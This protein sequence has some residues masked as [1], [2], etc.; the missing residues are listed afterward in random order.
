MLQPRSKI[1]RKRFKQIQKYMKEHLEPAEYEREMELA[2]QF[3]KRLLAT[4]DGALWLSF[5]EQKPV[6]SADAEAPI[7]A[8]F[9]MKDG[10]QLLWASPVAR[11]NI[12]SSVGGAAAFKKMIAPMLKEVMQA[13]Q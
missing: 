9:S 13:C 2:K 8:D 7:K 5:Y 11:A 6:D 12:I 3:S 4:K 10:M 1:L